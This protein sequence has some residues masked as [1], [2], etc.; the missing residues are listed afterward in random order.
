MGYYNQDR[1]RKEIGYGA[2]PRG[3][4]AHLGDKLGEAERAEEGQGGRAADQPLEGGEGS[5]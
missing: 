3:W 1:I 4:T 5:S 2:D